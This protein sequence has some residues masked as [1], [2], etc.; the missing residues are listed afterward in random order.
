M[1]INDEE[2][3]EYQ[4]IINWMKCNQFLK[5]LKSLK[6]EKSSKYLYDSDE[7]KEKY[8]SIHSY[9]IDTSIVNKYLDMIEHCGK[10]LLIIQGKSWDELRRLNHNVLDIYNALSSDTKIAICD[11]FSKPEQE[12]IVNGD[13][14]SSPLIG[15][16]RIYVKGTQIETTDYETKNNEIIGKL[17]QFTHARDNS[18]NITRILMNIKT[19]Y[20]GESISKF[21]ESDFE[22]LDK[23]TSYLYHILDIHFSKDFKEKIDS[24]ER[25]VTQDEMN[26]MGL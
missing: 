17:T 14:F 15:L 9:V 8:N 12:Y 19:R 13:R 10:A 5:E 7:S 26:K 22:F 18:G 6:E 21:T 11:R 1:D 23:F 20:P 2:R 3:R 16:Q 25:R 24:S 4:I